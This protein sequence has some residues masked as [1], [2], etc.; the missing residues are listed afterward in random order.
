MNAIYKYSLIIFLAFFTAGCGTSSGDNGSDIEAIQITNTTEDGTQN[1]QSEKYSYIPKGDQL[2][3]SMAYRFLNLTT[4]GATK[5]DVEELRRLGVIKWVDRQLGYG[6]NATTDS[7]TYACLAQSKYINP[8]G[9]NHPINYYLKEDTTQS[10]P[11]KRNY[12]YAFR[13]YFFSNWFRFAVDNPKQLRLRVAYALSQIIVAA[14]SNFIFGDRYSALSAYY[15]LLIKNA[16]GNYGDILKEISSNP[17]MGYYLT[18]YGNQKKYKNKKGELVYPDENYAREIMQLFSIGP[19]ILNKD[20]TKYTKLV[21]GVHQPV[22]TYTQKDVNE[23]ARVFT[24]LDFRLKTSAFGTN[25]YYRGSDTIHKMECHQEYHDDEA[26]TVLGK[27]IPAGGDC[28]SD[29]DKAIDILM[30]NDNVAPFIVKHLIMRLTK[31]NPQTSYV[32]RVVNVFNDNGNGVKGDLKAVVR[33]ILLDQE[34]WKSSSELADLQDDKT[35]KYKEPILAITQILRVFHAKA[36]PKWKIVMPDNGGSGIN[37]A[38]TVINQ[39]YFYMDRMYQVIN[40]GPAQAQSVFGFYSND[41]VP[42]DAG[43]ITTQGLK[44]PEVQIQSDGF[45]P[46]YHNYVNRLFMNYEKNYVTN[47][48]GIGPGATKY[49]SMEQYGA[50][51]SNNAI[52]IYLNMDEYYKLAEDIIK[53]ET[54]KGLDESLKQRTPALSDDIKEKV[55]K[56]LVDKMDK[57]LLGGLMPSGMKTFLVSEFKGRLGFPNIINIKFF[58]YLYLKR[59]IHLIVTSDAYM[60][61]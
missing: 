29:I 52:K 23:M 13:S 25:G 26:K 20:G 45:F 47:P 17:A 9:Y 44:A 18:F 16:F 34:L 3:Y 21:N 8:D 1:T 15:D 7:L 4:F 46:N 43:G 58:H 39:P 31:S 28:Y 57:D 30:Q 40:Q 27:T 10:I 12:P 54:H 41:Y 5:E 14:D 2:T 50:I 19:I 22:T 61:E 49:N 35:L 42:S 36:M 32:Q 11:P 48:Y 38:K 33:A 60:V 59:M 24:G 55:T 37:I 56:A 51:L 6:Y 53:Q